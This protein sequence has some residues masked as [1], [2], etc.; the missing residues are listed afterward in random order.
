MAVSAK[1]ENPKYGEDTS[2]V[3][4]SIPGGKNLKSTVLHGNSF[5]CE[6]CEFISLKVSL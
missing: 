1:S 2:N 6:F 3:L 5:C 4:W